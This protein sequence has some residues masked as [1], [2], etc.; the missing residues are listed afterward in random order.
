[1]GEREYLMIQQ[2]RKPNSWS[3]SITALAMALHLSV[4]EVVKEAGHDGSEVIFPHLDEP[5]CRRGF[6]PQELVRI[7]WHHGFAMTPIELFPRSMSNDGT[8][9]HFVWWQDDSFV[10]ARFQ[11]IV[12][13]SFGVMEG[14]NVKC[15]HAVYNHYG[16]IWETDNY[17][18]KYDFS[19]TNCEERG[20]YPQRLWVFTRHTL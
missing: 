10:Q 17:R 9:S 5:M 1:M 4:E 16:Q 19:S 7:A 13:R 20:F 3:C 8:H 18:L 14:R 6:H 11:K 2:Q 12:K 15:H